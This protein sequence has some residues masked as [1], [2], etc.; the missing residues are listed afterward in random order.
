MYMTEYEYYYNNVPVS[1]KCRNNLIY[2]SLI[3]RDKKVFV[4]WYQNDTEYHRGENQVVDPEKMEEKWQ[5][6]IKYLTLMSEKFPNHV[7]EIIDIDYKNKKVF[8]YVD[9]VDFW[10]RAGC[11]TENY[12][13]VLPDWQEQMLDIISSHKIID[14]FKYSMHPSSY[15]LVDGKLKSINYFFTYHKSEPLISISD[16]E[17]H[18]YSRRQAE[19]RKHLSSLGIDWHVPQSFETLESLCWASFQTNFPKDFIDKVLCLK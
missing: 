14:L 19:M 16:V 9:G 10:E 11:T 6:E 15:F 2:T 8:L 1:G 4:Q 7:P 18:I 3:S 17:S 5:R 13:T 12:S